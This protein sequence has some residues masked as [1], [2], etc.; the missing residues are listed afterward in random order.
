[1]NELISDEYKALLRQKHDAKPWGG[2]GHTWC[3]LIAPLLNRL[4]AQL[5]ILDFGCGR[6]TFKREMQILLPDATIYEYDP[7]VAGKDVL[8][9]VP[10][11]YVVCTD[12]MEHVEEDRVEYTLRTLN[13]LAIEGIFFNIDTALSRSLLPDGTNTHITV[14]PAKWW[15]HQL[16]ENF[17]G[18]V[19][20]DH[21]TGKNQLVV[22]GHREWERDG[23]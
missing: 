7:G 3:F 20:K 6:G 18:M 17:P 12:V 21:P 1:M 14:K 15:M 2:K 13:F 16:R 23:D 9:M 22:S 10:C 8:S 19:W 5:T 11:D 4:P